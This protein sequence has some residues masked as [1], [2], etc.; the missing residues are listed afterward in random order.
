[1]YLPLCECVGFFNTK[2]I[3]MRLFKIILLHEMAK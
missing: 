1:M 2:I 3:K